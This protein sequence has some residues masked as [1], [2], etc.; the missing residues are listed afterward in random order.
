L[1]VT[2]EK[3]HPLSEELSTLVNKTKEITDFKGMLLEYDLY[4]IIFVSN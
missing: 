3:L 1:K 4:N 2:K